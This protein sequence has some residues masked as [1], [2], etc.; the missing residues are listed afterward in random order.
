MNFRRKRRDMSDWSV[1]PNFEGIGK[2]WCTEHVHFC[3]LNLLLKLEDTNKKLF[4]PRCAK[5]FRKH[6]FC[7]CSIDLWNSFSQNVIDSSTVN[8]F[9]TKLDKESRHF[10]FNVDEVYKLASDTYKATHIL[11]L[12]GM[13]KYIQMCNSNTP[14]LYMEPMLKKC[15]ISHN[16][17]WK[18]EEKAC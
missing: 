2:Y 18:W 8:E 11:L 10:R 9:K 3:I 13:S 1:V 17:F 15:D 4:K 14:P 16:K 5:G 6:S 7:I 12:M